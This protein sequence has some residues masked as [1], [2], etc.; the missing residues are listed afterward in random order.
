M[1]SY[2]PYDYTPICFGETLCCR[3]SDYAHLESLTEVVF[4]LTSDGFLCPLLQ[5]QSQETGFGAAGRFCIIAIACIKPVT[6]VVQSIDLG[7]AFGF[8]V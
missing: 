4:P 5:F 8:V 2:N 3:Y 6:T 7:P 1:E